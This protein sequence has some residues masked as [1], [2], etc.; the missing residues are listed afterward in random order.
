[1]CVSEPDLSLLSVTGSGDSRISVDWRKEVECKLPHQDESNLKEP[2]LRVIGKCIVAVVM[3]EG[4]GDLPIFCG[5]V[6]GSSLE[7]RRM[8]TVQTFIPTENNSS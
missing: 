1:M 4:G 5:T 6:N 2:K 3:E 7:I 8:H